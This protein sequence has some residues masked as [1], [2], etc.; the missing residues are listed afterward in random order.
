MLKLL[1][2]VEKRA[3]QLCWSPRGDYIV[4]SGLRSYNGALEFYNVNDLETMAVTEHHA[5]KHLIWDPSGRYVATF[6]SSWEQ[7]S[8]MSSENGYC[9]W[10]FYGKLLQKVNKE[11]FYELVWRPRPPPLLSDEKIQE[12][13]KNLRSYQKKYTQEESRR[14][15][16]LK[17]QRQMRRDQLRKSFDEYLAKKQVEFEEDEAERKK[18]YGRTLS[19]SGDITEYEIREFEQVVETRIEILD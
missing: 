15:G 5:A 2:T 13:K 11:K 14:K 12:I 10:T 9:I 8:F 3:N 7:V 18:I 19:L 17:K 6:A 1:K 16:E 4:L